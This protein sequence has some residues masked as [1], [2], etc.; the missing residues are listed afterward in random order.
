MPA[1]RLS[2]CAHA[3]VFV[4]LVLLTV[5]EVR[6][7]DR[8]A[9]EELERSRRWLLRSAEE[10]ARALDAAA[11]AAPDEAARADL[12]AEL[13]PRLAREV[14]GADAAEYLVTIR[15]HDSGDVLFRF[16]GTPADV[17]AEV[18]VPVLAARARWAQFVS[19]S[20]DSTPDV[21]LVSGDSRWRLAL[22]RRDGTLA[23]LAARS[24]LHNLAL[25]LGALALLVAGSAWSFLA[26]RR[27]R[28]LARRELEFVAGVSH[29]LRT[30][31]AVIR[32]AAANLDDGIVPAERVGEYARLIGG[33]TARMQAQVEKVLAFSMARGGVVAA[34]EHIDADEVAR[35]AL[36]DAR[37][38]CAAPDGALVSGSTAPGASLTGDAGL[39]RAALVNLLENGLLHGRA[40]VELSVRVA[41]DSVVFEVE[42]HGPGLLED[43]RERLFEPFFRGREARR[44]CA[45]G[46][47]LGLAL[48]AEAARAHG[49][50]VQAGSGARG[51]L[52]RLT[53][54]RG[55]Q[56]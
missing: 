14:L 48:V 19:N 41:P 22:A 44:S 45:P 3:L 11:E 42:D 8:M 9:G 56:P 25:G 53:I 35:G 43:E 34:R 32:S 1:L 16:E 15:A 6:W 24:R 33:E 55:L 36:A 21:G 13:V 7:I 20:G 29:E 2:L 17:P 12:C 47:G 39:L 54:P 37:R 40:P 49:G 51:A 38:R 31:L 28:S 10:L 50:S 30:P 26:E 46:S 5:L 23:E 18:E 27:A 4:G 52:F